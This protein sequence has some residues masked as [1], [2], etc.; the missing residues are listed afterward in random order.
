MSDKRNSE[1]LLEGISESTVACLLAMVQGNILALTVSHLLIAAQTGVIAGS[2]AL[3]VGLL[4]RTKG[5]WVTPVVLAITTAAVDFL[6]H[7]GPFGAVA[8]EAIVTGIA[9]GVLSWLVGEVLR[10]QRKTTN[11]S[12][13]QAHGDNPESR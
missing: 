8:K 7:P 6:I 11:S 10:R 5:P 9:A 12:T 1:S 3:A 2:L 13:N 4:A